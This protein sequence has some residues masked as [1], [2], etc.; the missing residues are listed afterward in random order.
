MP[1]VSDAASIKDLPICCR[2]ASIVF[3]LVVGI[4]GLASAQKPI[5]A[6]A[7]EAQQAS[8]FCLQVQQKKRILARGKKIALFSWV[9]VVIVAV[10]LWRRLP[11]HGQGLLVKSRRP[12]PATRKSTCE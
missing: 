4:T 5:A 11:G 12:L 10:A 6:L 8:Q 2:D 1:N 9:S 3:N 7:G